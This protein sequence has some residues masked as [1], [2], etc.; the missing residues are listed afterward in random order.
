VEKFEAAL[1]GGL[2]V[3][4]DRF[5]FVKPTLKVRNLPEKVR[6]PEDTYNVDK[7]VRYWK[8]QAGDDACDL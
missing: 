8:Y 1:A 4:R 2:I 3:V 7:N 6:K 5:P